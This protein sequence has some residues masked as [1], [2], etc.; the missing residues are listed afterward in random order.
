M[1]SVGMSRSAIMYKIA[2]QLEEQQ[3]EH[4]IRN[5]TIA[6]MWARLI[7]N[8]AYRT[9]CE[10]H[11]LYAAV[12]IDFSRCDDIYQAL[13]R[14][15]DA[16][17]H[18]PADTLA[19]QS[20]D[21]LGWTM[22]ALRAVG[23]TY[24]TSPSER[25]LTHYYTAPM[26]PG[27]HGMPLYTSEHE[28]PSPTAHERI[29]ISTALHDT[30]NRW[31]LP[32]RMAQPIETIIKPDQLDYRRSVGV[33]SENRFYI[34]HTQRYMRG[35]YDPAIS[36]G[37]LATV[38]IKDYGETMQRVRE[39]HDTLRACMTTAEAAGVLETTGRSLAQQPEGSQLLS[40]LLAQQ[41]YNVV[42]DERTAPTAC[43]VIDPAAV[44]PTNRSILAAYEGTDL[45]PNP[46]VYESVLFQQC[47]P[48]SRSA[49]LTALSMAKRL[50]E[51]GWD[52]ESVRQLTGWHCWIDGKWRY[53]LDDSNAHIAQSALQADPLTPGGQ[54]YNGP[55]SG[56]LHHPELYR[57]Y[58]ALGDYQCQIRIVPPQHNMEPYESEI[59][60]ESQILTSRVQD[61]AE[62]LLALIHEAQ[63]HVQLVENFARGAAPG[64]YAHISSSEE[65]LATALE[66]D[67]A[68]LLEACDQWKCDARDASER[69]GNTIDSR[70][71]YLADNF[72]RD[73]IEQYQAQLKREG[74]TQYTRYCTQAGEY[75]ARDT[76]SRLNMSSDKRRLTP[77]YQIEPHLKDRLEVRMTPPPPTQELQ[78]RGAL[79]RTPDKYTVYLGPDSDT[80]T[81]IHELGG[82]VFL[83]L[84]HDAASMPHASPTVKAD[85]NKIKAHIGYNGIGPISRE[86]HE[87]W[88]ET[89]EQYFLQAEPSPHTDTVLERL[90]RWMHDI[91]DDARDTVAIPEEI[92]SVMDRLYG[93]PAAQIDYD[94][95][96][97]ALESTSR[98][99]APRSQ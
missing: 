21:E 88:A 65:Q 12:E 52:T 83:D 91:Y 13:G 18:L 93:Q 11:E 98:P 86:Q 97:D 80:S 27:D 4:T 7:E 15:I 67:I 36:L 56:I 10:L 62:L 42:V 73:Q 60:H 63:H 14:Q 29:A 57:A 74:V 48:K 90:K 31:Q 45:Y 99:P 37:T 34:N 16:P 79:M 38:L 33:R 85:W 2:E 78:P 71:H 66:R 19:I 17:P 44:V 81:L 43:Y 40:R 64:D 69:L 24:P 41:G 96:R 77:P 54:Y 55:L 82:H 3:P 84:L 50:T 8:L 53:E 89:T 32:I 25:H 35:A 30:L 39:L 9:G 75:E 76:E 58:P 47:G 87:R 95:L 28:I 49:N 61:Q 72:R 59:I 1:N 5:Y 68:L 51:Q 23:P 94:A 20:T 46:P 26:A 92:R 70:I 22:D 6:E